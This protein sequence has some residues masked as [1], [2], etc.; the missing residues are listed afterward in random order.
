MADLMQR[1]VT[2]LIDLGGQGY[3]ELKPGVRGTIT[4]GFYW[5]CTWQPYKEDKHVLFPAGSGESIKEAVADWERQTVAMF[6]HLKQL[7]A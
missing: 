2:D 6:R 7:R 5:S 4:S 1:L 3:L